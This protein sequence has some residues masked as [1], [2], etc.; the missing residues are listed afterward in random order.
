MDTATPSVV[1]DE[2]QKILPALQRVVPVLAPG[3]HKGQAGKPCIP[4]FSIHSQ[5]LKSERFHG[6]AV[7]SRPFGDCLWYN[8]VF[9][10]EHRML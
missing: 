2:L 7:L 6:W 8:F 4:C 5:D 10:F 3:R 1:P 9:I